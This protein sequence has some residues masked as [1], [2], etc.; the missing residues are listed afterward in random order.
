MKNGTTSKCASAF[1]ILAAALCID[2]NAAT[3]VA[4]NRI[5]QKAGIDGGIACVLGCGDG[6]IVLELAHNSQFLILALDP[7][8]V[9]V[10]RAAQQAA[11]AG[12]LG[13]RVYVAQGTTKQI[14]FAD[15]YVDVLVLTDARSNDLDEQARLEIMRVLTPVRG[16]AIIGDRLLSK[17]PLPGADDWTHRLHGRDN[18]PVSSD[19]AFQMPAMLQYLAMPMQTSFQGAMLAGDGRRIEL[20]DWVSKKPD[21]VAVAG[22]LLAR[23]LY[24]GQILWQRELPRNIEPDTPVCALAGGRVYLAAGDACRVLVID[25]E[26]GG[27][28]SAIDLSGDQEQRVKWLA[29]DGGRLYALLGPALPVRT[30]FSFPIAH[31]LRLKQTQSGKTIVARDLDTGRPLWNHVEQATIDYHTIAVRGGRTYFYSEK[32]RLACLDSEGR[33]LWENSDTSW[34]AQLK[35]GPVRNANVEGVSTLRVGPEQVWLSIPG[36]NA[37]SM[38]SAKDGSLLWQGRAVNTDLFVG[39]RFYTAGGAVNPATGAVIQ[40]GNF[41][42]GGWCGIRTWVPALKSGLGHVAFG[43]RSPCGVGIFAAGGVVCVMP[44]QCDCWPSVRG[45]GGFATAGHVLEQIETSADH[46]L[47]TGP[48]PAGDLRAV[49]GDWPQYRGDIR[50]TGAATISAGDS[51][52]LRWTTPADQPFAAP[53]GHEKHRMQWLD[54]PTPPVTAGGMALSGASDGSVRAVRISD[55]TVAWTFWTGGAVLTAPALADGRVYAGS[56]DGWLYCIDAATGK[57]AW[58]W[59]G[60]PAQRRIMVYGKLMSSWPV[61]AVLAHEGTVYGVAGQWMQNGVVTFAL[62]AATGR[63]QWVHWT[64]PDNNHFLDPYLK[65]EDPAFAPAGQLAIVGKNLWIRDYL[66]VPAIFETATGRRIPVTEDMVEFQ[67]T[68]WNFGVWFATAGQ[69][70]LVAND[71]LVLQGGYPLLGNP[72]IRHDKAAARFIALRVNENGQIQALPHPPTAI[73]NSQIIPSLADGELL[74]VGGGS[75]RTQPTAATGLSLWTLAAWQGQ[76]A[77]LVSGDGESSGNDD[78]AAASGTARSQAD[79]PFKKRPNRRAYL[80][81]Q[82]AQWSRDDIEVNAVVLCSD[83]AVAA[84]GIRLPTDRPR[85]G[86]HPGFQRWELLALD[87]AT[88]GRRWSVALPGEPVFNGLAP[89]AA[90]CWVLTLGDGSLVCVGH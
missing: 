28:L 10:A 29:I 26:T 36:V 17:P 11:D 7:D 42:I 18:N 51:I 15:N 39:D 58:R 88:G 49:L 66:G 82:Q 67:K 25:A 65:R 14:P 74:I 69:D 76:F 40:P 31:D 50:R 56:G 5:L 64:R 83:A 23:S 71:R 6:E 34:M 8:P 35:R 2:A 78:P 38:F 62:D 89:A 19:T 20:S 21:R 59:R 70:I 43:M 63:Q 87:R 3:D 79:D 52:R 77:S 22:K 13:R 45:A 60:A 68:Y 73:P 81:M 44:S 72:D 57:L 90:D 48:A 85:Y 80:D 4:A 33:Q 1:L 53:E 46:P 86:V 30:P 27:D 16:R 84:V 9:N 12:V 32:T 37:A 75:S 55:G 47:E 61:T 54:R 24:N 41:S